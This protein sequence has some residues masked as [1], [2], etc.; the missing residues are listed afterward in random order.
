MPNYSITIN[1]RF[2]PFSYQELLAPVLAS[3]QAQQQIEEN[4]ANLATQASL[5]GSKANEQTDPIA[6]ARY[7]AYSDELNAM[8]EDLAKNGLTPESRRGMFDM[9]AR[10]AKDIVPIENA[11]QRRMQDIELERQA[12][13]KDP[14]LL[15]EG[16]AA[17]TSLDKYLENPNIR[18]DKAGYSGAMITKQVSDLAQY[19][20]QQLTQF[21][22]TGNLDPYTK[23]LM[24][25]WGMEPSDVLSYLQNPTAQNPVFDALV[26]TVLGSTGISGWDDD[27]AKSRALY[28][29]RQGIA[30]AMGKSDASTYEDYGSRKALEL[31]NALTLQRQKH[32]DEMEEAA[33]AASL[34]GGDSAVER[35]TNYLEAS[36][37]LAAH[38]RTYNSLT[39]GGAGS[40]RASYFGKTGTANPM[41]VYEE[42]KK[43]TSGFATQAAMQ[44]QAASKGAYVGSSIKD[45]ETEISKIKDRIMKK[46][47]V[48]SVLTD[49]QYNSLKE[50]G[51]TKNST[52]KEFRNEFK[53]RIDNKGIEYTHNSVNLPTDALSDVSERIVGSLVGGK[54]NA[55]LVWEMKPNGTL[56]K[57]MKGSDI[58][59]LEKAKVT[60]IYY[61]QQNNTTDKVHIVID[62]SKDVYVSPSVFKDSKVNQVVE[63]GNRILSMKDPESIKRSVAQFTGED[64]NSFSV[65]EAKNFVQQYVTGI[66]RDSIRGFN[67]NRSKT[68]SKL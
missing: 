42:I 28:Y 49:E 20:G 14:T 34:A 62:G 57:P 29:A 5:A 50:L 24:K 3:T 38:T 31:S 55:G 45:A 63:W 37:D 21:K 61:G 10:Y 23:T 13:L 17:T 59:K 1:S 48:T 64:V 27:E 22:T 47:G 43:Q 56:G 58:D 12:R 35:G 68:D 54:D 19:L 33:Y 32:Q 51:Y 66:I 30:P 15:M 25:K 40:L 16:S 4:Y 6:Y 2:R 7:K 18:A 65:T 39:T 26:G 60:D 44:T 8:A 53:S 41:A 9:R 36:G 52:F 46:Y 11:Y 67:K